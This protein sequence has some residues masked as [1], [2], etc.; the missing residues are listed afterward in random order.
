MS[1]T[2]EG[3]S[4][5][6]VL[7]YKSNFS[8]N[9]AKALSDEDFECYLLDSA[10]RRI[11]LV[12]KLRLEVDAESCIPRLYLELVPTEIEIE[13][14]IDEPLTNREDVVKQIRQ[15]AIG[16][17]EIFFPE[18]KNPSVW[19]ALSGVIGENENE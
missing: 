3:G 2:F 10:N 5:K 18:V 1:D 7:K 13:I 16:R 12:Q 15:Y 11:P 9:K 14:D 6:L 19:P 8:A 4:L 17:K